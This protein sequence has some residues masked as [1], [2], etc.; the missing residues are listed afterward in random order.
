MRI[1][2]RY[3]LTMA[4]VYSCPSLHCTSKCEKLANLRQRLVARRRK[5]EAQNGKENS[6]PKSASEANENS[7]KPRH[8]SDVESKKSP[9]NTMAP[10]LERLDPNEY[11]ASDFQSKPE[12]SKRAYHDD[13]ASPPRARTHEFEDRRFRYQESNSMDNSHMS[14]SRSE[15]MIGGMDDDDDASV[16][17]IELIQCDCCKRSF[18]P[19]VYEKH[20]DEDGQPKC[21]NN[22][23]KRTVFNSAKVCVM[24]L[25][26]NLPFT[27]VE[28]LISF[29]PFNA[30]YCR[31]ELLTIPIST[32]TKRF[33]CCKKTRRLPRS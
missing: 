12:K 10:S 19:K 4:R 26:G 24:L 30:V 28:M 20:F 7:G 8:E 17:N 31:R 13:M 9:N 25:P 32:L 18:A 27:C 11:T 15:R 23:K 14:Q 16:V 22:D 2:H 6:V 21:A 5:R 33:K 1:D 3:P 29:T